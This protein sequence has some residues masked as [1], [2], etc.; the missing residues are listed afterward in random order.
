MPMPTPVGVYTAK[1][2]SNHT[3]SLIIKSDST[4]RYVSYQPG[5]SLPEQFSGKWKVKKNDVF[6]YAGNDPD[7]YGQVRAVVAPEQKIIRMKVIRYFGELQKGAD[8]VELL[9][10]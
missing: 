10:K 8:Q 4:Y 7:P 3:D 6:L 1:T 5:M 2:A 9:P